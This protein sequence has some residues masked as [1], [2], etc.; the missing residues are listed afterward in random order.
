MV[1]YS[2][3]FTQE[4]GLNWSA[5]KKL[6]FPH[7][8]L[9]KELTQLLKSNLNAN[10]SGAI[11]EILKSNRGLFEVLDVAFK[12]FND[13][14]GIEKTMVAL[15]WA[16]FRDRFASLYVYKAIH[17]KFPTRTDMG[18]IEDIQRLENRFA[19]MSVSGHSR[20]FLLGLYLK[21]AQIRVQELEKN[22]FIE[23]QLPVDII[24]SLLKI[25]QARAEK[26]DWVILMVHHFI[27]A[28]GEKMLANAL[29]NEKSF[30]EIYELMDESDKRHMHDNFLSYGMSI[31][32]PEIFL[33]EKI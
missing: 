8:I 6:L 27:E 19:E 28:L 23:Y 33:Y 7:V 1:K 21:L 18:L 4:N 15:G 9:P 22:K 17:G 30:D 3:A 24:V 16:N 13:G 5:M 14:R 29:V 11:F 32:E 25:S 12:E 31:F 2:Q 10:N 26:I 20:A